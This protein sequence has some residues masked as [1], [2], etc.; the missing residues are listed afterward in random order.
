MSQLLLGPLVRFA[1]RDEATVWVETD[2]PAEVE[3]R[4]EHAPVA[5]ARTWTVAGHH[6]ALVRCRGLRVNAA[7]PYAVDVD[8]VR[9]WPPR[10]S[11]L[12]PSVLRTH[13]EEEQARI[14]FGSCRVAAPHEPPWSLTKDEDPKG[15]EADA[16]RT[17]A[18]RMRGEPA[19]RWPHLLLMLGDQVYADEVS[20]E[21]LERIRARRDTSRPPG[22]EVADFEEFALLYREAWSEPVLRWLLSTV[23]SAMIFD[24]H[25]VHDDWNTSRSW[26]EDMR[27]EPWWEERITGAFMSYAVYQHWGNVAPDALEDDPIFRAVRDAPDGTEALRAFAHRA[28]SELEG[29]RWSFCRDVGPARVV[30]VDSRAGRVLEPGARAMVDADEWSW[31]V[32]HARGGPQHLVVGSSLPLMLGPALHH[33]EAWNEAV[34]DGAWGRLAARVGE[35]V[36][37]AADFEHWSAFH[38]SFEA[39]CRHLGEVAAGRRGPAPATI[40]VLS[41]DVHHAYLAEVA[42]PRATQARSRV[43]QA[44]CSPFRNPLD[45]RERR[46]IRFTWS[47]AGALLGRALARSA[48]VPDPPVRWRLAHDE[49]WFDNQ[50]ATLALDGARAE[51]A[52]DRAVPDGDHRPRLE[53]VFERE[54]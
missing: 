31:I 40:T 48:G 54:L 4:P 16:L 46:A 24:D 6:Y 11:D 14:V 49:P 41:G 10:G 21:A 19:E 13:S 8:G 28:D 43:W 15:R 2:G 51:L 34:C 9:A 1:G 50:V 3:V 33:A 12:P 35:R 25:D 39:L 5:R 20:P 45:H 22:E 7:T 30:V 32:E 52:I 18:L 36:R 42:F 17:Y 23:P 53:R 27:R 38:G 44:V 29:V 37:R 26:V 47:R